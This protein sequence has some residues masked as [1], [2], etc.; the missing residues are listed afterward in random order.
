MYT[1]SVAPDFDISFGLKLE[2]V[3]DPGAV[4]TVSIRPVG[5]PEGKISLFFVKDDNVVSQVKSLR[6]SALPKASA[7]LDARLADARNKLAS[8]LATLDP[9][10]RAA[11]TALDVTADG[12]IVRGVIATSG[13]ADAIV[14]YG[15]V[16]GGTLMSAG[17]S[18]IPGGRIDSFVWNWWQSDS[19]LP[20]PW[21]GTNEQREVFDDF[22]WERT[23][24]AIASGRVCLQIKGSRRTADGTEE[25]GLVWGE[26]CTIKS[27][28][29][30]VGVPP[31]KQ[32]L[33]V[34]DFVNA[35]DPAPD[36]GVSQYI[37]GHVSLVDDNPEPGRLKTN[38]LVYFTGLRGN[39]PLEGVARAI[40]TM[41]RRDA[42]LCAVLVLPTGTLDGRRS[43]IEERL[44][45]PGERFGA[46][47]VITEDYL[48]GWSR[49]FAVAEG[50]STHLMN[51][52]GEFVWRRDGELDPAAIAR[53]LDEHALPAPP[54][55]KVP[56]RL[57]V[58][59]GARPRDTVFTDERWEHTSLRRLRGRRILLVFWQSWSSPCLRELRRLAES[60]RERDA[61]FVLAVNGGEAREVM[62]EVRRTHG[63]PFPL[64]QDPERRIAELYGCLLYTSP[65]PRDS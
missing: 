41:R 33:Y 23:P 57:G 32:L 31:W 17:S 42:P 60:W 11:F 54:P 49:A 3:L 46:E 40:A 56:I 16:D 55:Q 2:V 30:P 61:P 53:A 4:P 14:S 6:D 34:P 26:V 22:L 50:P 1:D 48:G 28:G 65:S 64:I 24:E 39:R 44:G 58:S 8:A 13:R 21:R 7:L 5:D 12:I 59:P 27:S 63:L 18:W 36:F 19:V 15:D 35:P 37:A 45:S 10:A 38:M 20:L 9:S 52:L 62:A 47:L 29:P 25:S 51:A 43:E